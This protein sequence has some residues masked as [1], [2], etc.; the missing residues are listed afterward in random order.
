MNEHPLIA[1]IDDDASVCKAIVRLLRS[2][3][4]DALAYSSARAFLD[5]GVSHNPDCIVLDIQMPDMNGFELRDQLNRLPHRIPVI[6]ISAQNDDAFREKALAGGAAAYL[7]KPFSD[8]EL[9]DA[10][11]TAMTS[12]GNMA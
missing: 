9:L 6:F 4:I 1:V 8:E 2:S 12:E 7:H 5:Y 10:I 11:K 3:D